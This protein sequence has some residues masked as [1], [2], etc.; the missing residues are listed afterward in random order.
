MKNIFQKKTYQ[1]HWGCTQGKV[2]LIQI[3]MLKYI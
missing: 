1:V 3:T 2:Q